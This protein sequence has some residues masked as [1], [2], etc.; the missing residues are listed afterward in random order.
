M[1][2]LERLGRVL[3]RLALEQARQQEV[4]LLEAQQLFVE[5]ELVEAREQAAGL[6]L[7][8][9]GGDEQE[10]G[11]DVE[12]ELL[13]AVELGDV[14]V[15]DLAERDLPELH[16]LLEDEVE[17]QVEGSL[18]HRGADRVR[19]R[20]ER[21]GRRPPRTASRQ[22]TEAKLTGGPGAACSL[23]RHAARV[24]GHPAHRG[25]PSGQLP[26]RGAAL[27]GRPGAVDGPRPDPLL[28]G[29]PP[30][31]HAAVGHH[32]LRRGHPP[33]RDAAARLR[34]RPRALHPLR[35]EP[36]APAHRA[37]LAA[38]LHRHLRRIGPDD[39]VQGEV[40]KGGSR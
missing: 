15:D 28:R 18:E 34:A 25:D 12:V 11:G 5:L 19:H 3:E 26:R 36:R 30:R 29:R 13:E 9:R 4:A 27:G 8:Q 2:T 40:A 23:T 33:H 7:H 35:A 1:Q 37:H 17:E 38:E 21:T 20:V 39:P 24:L 32:H 16:L 6:E 14:G 10:L 22:G 31:P